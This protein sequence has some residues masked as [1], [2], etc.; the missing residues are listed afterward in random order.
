M[1]KKK[2]EREIVNNQITSDTN[3]ENTKNKVLV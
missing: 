2:R 3:G 1:T